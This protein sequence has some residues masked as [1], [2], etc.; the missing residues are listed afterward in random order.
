MLTG[1]AAARSSRSQAGSAVAADMRPR[2]SRRSTPLLLLSLILSALP[3]GLVI[4]TPLVRGHAAAQAWNAAPFPLVSPPVVLQV[5]RNDC[6]PAVVATLLTWLGSPVGL[7]EVT[8][9]A[10]LGPDGLNLGEFAR[11]AH[12]FGLQGAWYRATPS[13]LPSLPGPFVAHLSAQ[14][15]SAA[16]AYPGSAASGS[17]ASGSAAS[18]TAARAALPPVT[19]GHLVVVW[20]VGKGAVLVSDPAV[21]AYSQSLEGFSRA[22]TGRVYLL[23]Q[24]T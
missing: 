16:S 4:A 22:F 3:V 19:A 12:A 21:G 13:D 2:A 9:E 24:A 6:G 17:A 7:P 18:G 8:A 15:S 14:I 23:E 1:Q 11:L 5:A 10:Q 20:G